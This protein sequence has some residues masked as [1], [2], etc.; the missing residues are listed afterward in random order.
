MMRR[1]TPSSGTAKARAASHKATADGPSRQR[2]QRSLPG[3]S[4]PAFS[5]VARRPRPRVV[6]ARLGPVL[7]TSPRLLCVVAACLLAACAPRGSISFD[8]DGSEIGDV[9]QILVATSR[10]PSPGP[11]VLSGARSPSLAFFD[12]SVSVPPER[13]VGTVSFSTTSEPDPT[14]DFVTVS[15][16]RIS[17]LSDLKRI[18]NARAASRAPID[19]EAVIFVHGYNS[20]FAE[21]L[22]RQAQLGHD[23]GIR[24]ISV[25][26]S[27]PS[28]ARL[29]SYAQDRESALFARDGLEALI[30]ALAESDVERILVMGH[31]MGAFLVMETIRQMALADAPALLGKVSAVILVAPDIDVDVFQTQGARLARFD[32]PLY[33]FVSQRDRALRFSSL[34]RGRGERLGSLSDSVGLSDLPVIL[35]DVTDLDAN[36]DPLLHFKVA[37]SP[38][39]IA[40]ISQL[41]TA[42]LDLFREAESRPGL[43]RGGVQLVDDVAT[44]LLGGQPR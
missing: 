35:I 33:V 18:V 4:R 16:G 27:W 1:W 23:F 24:G 25:N 43:L 10:Q 29:R 44:T 26:Y 6:R 20:T 28:S 40:Y 9:R 14:T 11:G 17:D 42:G 2:C 37:T 31:S 30:G 19:R 39:M 21:G 8:P 5:N 12:F 22:Y 7:A 32:V 34:L 15:A 36:E 13:T 3:G 38:T 41:G